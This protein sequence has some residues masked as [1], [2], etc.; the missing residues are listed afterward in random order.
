MN[1][2]RQSV[3]IKNANESTELDQIKKELDVLKI[4]DEIDDKN[5]I[6]QTTIDRYTKWKKEFLKKHGKTLEEW[7]KLDLL[8]ELADENVSNDWKSKLTLAFEKKQEKYRHSYVLPD[9]A[10][11]KSEDKTQNTFPD[12]ILKN[13]TN[14]FEVIN[15]E[16]LIVGEEIHL[17]FTNGKGESRSQTGDQS[18]KETDDK[19]S[20]I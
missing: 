11:I 12:E 13:L 8:K 16:Y 20:T 2:L 5:S 4:K 10:Y 3:L 17:T 14:R 9:I 6:I 18:K 19:R 15:T 1:S 7:N